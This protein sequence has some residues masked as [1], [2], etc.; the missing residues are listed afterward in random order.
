[1]LS[2]KKIIRGRA[3]LGEAEK[4]AKGEERGRQEEGWL[5]DKKEFGEEQ[6]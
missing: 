6:G 5:V 3:R 1:M 2:G 4:K